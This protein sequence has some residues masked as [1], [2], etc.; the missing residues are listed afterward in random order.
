M[1]HFN[2]SL[3][4]PDQP[5]GSLSNGL[6][7]R[8]HQDGQLMLRIQALQQ[9]DNAFSGIDIEIPGLVRLRAEPEARKQASEQSR[10]AGISPPDNWLGDA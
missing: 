9:I 8:D 2:A 10:P 6:I 3:F 4:Q 5:L 7:M 1:K